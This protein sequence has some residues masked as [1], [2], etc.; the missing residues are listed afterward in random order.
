MSEPPRKGSLRESLLMQY[1][2]KRDLIE[3]ARFR[4]LATAITNKEKASDIFEEYRKEAFPWVETQKNRDAENTKRLLQEEVKR[5]ALGIRPLWEATKKVRSRMKT[6][7]IEAERPNPPPQRSKE[8]M[9]KIY[10]KLGTV[11]P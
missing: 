9:A 8:E 10:S 11:K 7:I 3:H 5:G 6:R 1:V 2:L 4:A